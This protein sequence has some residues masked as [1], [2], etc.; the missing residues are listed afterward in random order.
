MKAAASGRSPRGG[1]APAPLPLRSAARDRN[2]RWCEFGLSAAIT[3]YVV[4]CHFVFLAHRGALW[5]DEAQ[6]VN[7]ALSPTFSEFWRDLAIDTFPS[8]WPAT[9]KCWCSLYGDSDGSLRVLGF[10]V[11]L[12]I[13]VSVWHAAR[14]VGRGFPLLALALFALCPTVI[15]YGDTVRGYGLGLL[16]LP[17]MYAR[18]WKAAAAPTAR[19]A[20]WG[21]LAA[22]LAV[23][24]MYFNAVL[25]LALGAASAAVAL[26]RQT[27]RPVLA[28]GGIG[29]LAAVSL[30]PYAPGMAWQSQWRDIMRFDISLSWIARMVSD[31]ANTAGSFAVWVWLGATVLAVAAAVYTAAHYARDRRAYDAGIFAGAAIVAG[32]ASYVAFIFITGGRT[33]IWYY[34]PLMAFLAIGFDAVFESGPLAGRG[35]RVFRLCAAGLLL[36]LTAPAA[37]SECHVRMTNVDLVARTLTDKAGKDDLIVVAPWWPGV[38][39]ARYYHGATP[40]TTLPDLGRLRLLR[41]DILKQRM[42][43]REPI[44]PVLQRCL[45]TLRAGHQIWIVGGL[46]HPPKEPPRSPPPIPAGPMD[47]GPYT[48]GWLKEL[49][50]FQSQHSPVVNKLDVACPDPVLEIERA[51]LLWLQGQ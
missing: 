4:A 29:A 49:S 14:Q 46:P 50:Y 10:L 2:I 30:L 28:V 34:M 22:V 39:F 36:V 21:L 6:I 8:L 11:G 51:D 1:P 19:N 7:I 47:E 32:I 48:T 3:L 25:L 15:R 44:Q 35:G 17:L 40:W 23:Q 45:D 12:S 31:A 18:V 24:T 9:V 41:Y 13:V 38:T 42:A 26:R 33:N 27:W 43:E 5:R 20:A 37:W 16:F